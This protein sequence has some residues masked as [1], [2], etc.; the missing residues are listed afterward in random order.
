MCPPACS[1]SCCA[2]RG[3]GNAEILD[4]TENNDAL[5]APQRVEPQKNSEKFNQN[6]P[7]YLKDVFEPGKI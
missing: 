5:V 7:D 2:S 6:I 1:T 3:F 4:Q